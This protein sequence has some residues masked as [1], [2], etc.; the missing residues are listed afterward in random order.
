[1]AVTQARREGVGEGGL[2]VTEAAEAEGGGPKSR[3]RQQA[4]A[5]AV[6][7]AAPGVPHV[8]TAVDAIAA[9][10]KADREQQL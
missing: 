6:A 4:A 5:A 10:V 7:A 9:P 1:M 8:L 3:Q 2:H